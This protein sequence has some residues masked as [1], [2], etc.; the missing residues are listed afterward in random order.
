MSNLS[1]RTYQTRI[2]G[3]FDAPLSAY[4]SLMAHVEHRLFADLSSGKISQDLKASYLTSFHITARQF[5]AVR[6]RLEGK[7]DSIRQLLSERIVS[8]KHQIESLEAKVPHL[9]N[10]HKLHQKKRRLFTL[11]HQLRKLEIAQKDKKISLCFGSRKLFR[12]QFEKKA[13]GYVT[14]VDWQNDW[15]Q[16]RASEI[17]IL[18]S[19]D[20]ASGNQSCTATIAQDHSINLRVRLPDALNAQFGKY[21]QI[22]NVRFAYGHDAIVAAIRNNDL[23]KELAHLKNP[24]YKTHGQAI[25][26][27]FKKDAKGWR[28]FASVNTQLPIERKGPTYSR[29]LSSFTYATT[30][31]HLKSRGQ[32]KGIE[33]QSV[34]P[35]FTSL[36]GRVNFAKRYGITIHKA[37]ALSIGRRY[38]GVSERMPQGQR[39]IPDGKGGYVTLDL[40]VRNRSRHVWHQWGQLNRKFSVALTAHFRAARTDPRV[41][42]NDSCDS[43]RSRILS[44]RF[45]HANR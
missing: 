10:K 12:A 7:M 11:K 26:F 36:I 24:D 32:A 15:K 38:L 22:P 19:K 42:K 43:K 25:T 5:N 21:L 16:A 2:L 31:S 27:L 4:A 33:V 35:A 28:V 14:Q 3:W 13:N 39:D 29:M 45:R 18:G 17:F 23:R 8:K 40:P 6:I 34:N 9:N 37:A 44:A 30:I 1:T 20:E 41:H